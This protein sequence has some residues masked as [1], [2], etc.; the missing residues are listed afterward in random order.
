[1][2]AGQTGSSS[3]R[4]FAGRVHAVAHEQIDLAQPGHTLSRLPNSASRRTFPGIRRP[5]V[6]PASAHPGTPL[7][8]QTLGEILKIVKR[9]IQIEFDEFGWQALSAEARRQGVSIEDLVYHAAIYYLG[10]GSDSLSRRVPQLSQKA[11]P[12]PSPP[13]G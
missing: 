8:C 2:S 3:K 4:T 9:R 7:R 5:F 6:E 12:E 13:D 10:T 1:M 11:D